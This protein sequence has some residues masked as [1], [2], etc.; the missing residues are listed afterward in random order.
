MRRRRCTSC[1]FRTDEEF[2]KAA[3]QST[4]CQG[5]EV[6]PPSWSSAEE[7]RGLRWW[8]GTFWIFCSG[9][10][11]FTRQCIAHSELPACS[12]CQDFSQARLW[13]ARAIS[14]I[15]GRSNEGRNIQQ[16]AYIIMG[17]RGTGLCGTFCKA[18]EVPKRRLESSEVKRRVSRVGRTMSVLFA[19]TSDCPIVRSIS[20]GG[21]CF[22][23]LPW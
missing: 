2:G 4:R 11:H 23:K 10:F 7:P 16:L 20:C 1:C 3:F 18:L 9:L 17:E 12:I 15:F 22:S 21:T 8:P 5:R 19:W 6:I 13:A 14:L